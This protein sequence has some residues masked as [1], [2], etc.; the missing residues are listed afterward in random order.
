MSTA[1]RVAASSRAERWSCELQAVHEEVPPDALAAVL[2]QLVDHFVHD[3]ARPEVMTLGLKTVRELCE[4]A[5]LIMT[6][7]LLQVPPADA[8]LRPVQ[9]A[10]NSISRL[11]QKTVKQHE[12]GSPEACHC[13]VCN[14]QANAVSLLTCYVCLDQIIVG[15]TAVGKRTD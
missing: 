15:L 2:R 10:N 1:S 7:E 9:S 3:R 14:I 13:T 5:P 6:P 12:P 4:R 11:M 8:C